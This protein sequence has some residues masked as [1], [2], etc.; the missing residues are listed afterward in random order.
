MTVLVG[1]ATNCG[2]PSVV[3]GADKMHSYGDQSVARKIAR[4]ADDSSTNLSSLLDFLMDQGKKRYW[5][6]VWKKNSCV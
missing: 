1:L 3:L 5:F 4:I 2:T 6:E